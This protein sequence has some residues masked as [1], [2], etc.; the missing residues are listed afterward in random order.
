MAVNGH[1][2]RLERKTMAKSNFVYG[3]YIATTPEKL[4]TALVDAAIPKQYWRRHRNE[5]DW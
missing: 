5:S 1:K 2:Q 3:T 4:W